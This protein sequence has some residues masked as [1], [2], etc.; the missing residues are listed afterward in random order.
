MQSEV[1]TPVLFIE[2]AETSSKSKNAGER[3]TTGL[4]VEWAIVPPLPFMEHTEGQ[5]L[6]DGS[7]TPAAP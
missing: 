5:F 7:W 3:P 1:N 4:L 6:F 2:A